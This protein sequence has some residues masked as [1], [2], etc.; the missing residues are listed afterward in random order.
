MYYYDRR[1]LEIKP[2]PTNQ[3]DIFRNFV[4]S[5]PESWKRI[6]QHIYTHDTVQGIKM[7][8]KLKESILLLESQNPINR[9]KGEKLF[10]EFMEQYYRLHRLQTSLTSPSFGACE[11]CLKDLDQFPRVKKHKKFFKNADPKMWD[12]FG[13]HSESM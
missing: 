2:I 12:I 9:S 8:D 1:T 7:Y 13:M 10:T 3:Y 4:F 5:E 6:F 11:Y